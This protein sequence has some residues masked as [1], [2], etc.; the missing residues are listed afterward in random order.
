[1]E[2]LHVLHLGSSAIFLSNWEVSYLLEISDNSSSDFDSNNNFSN[3][4]DLAPLVIKQNKIHEK[5]P[6][7]S[8]DSTGT[9]KHCRH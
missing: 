1:M 2:A 5:N 9:E 3:F 8:K 6:I 4:L 7:T